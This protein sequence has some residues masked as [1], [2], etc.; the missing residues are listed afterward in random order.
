MFTLDEEFRAKW[1]WSGEELSLGVYGLEADMTRVREENK[2]N[3]RQHE[4]SGD[5]HK[6]DQ[7]S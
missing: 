6:I 7:R 2:R 3:I 4:R 5:G 1:L